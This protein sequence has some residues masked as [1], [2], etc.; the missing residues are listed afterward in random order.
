MQIILLNNKSKGVKKQLGNQKINC[1]VDSCEH[2]GKGDK[3]KLSGIVVTPS[4]GAGTDVQKSEDSMC[5]SFSA[6]T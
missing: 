3:C 4:T 5:G 6:R 2:H 1:S